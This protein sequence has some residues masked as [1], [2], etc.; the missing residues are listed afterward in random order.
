MSLEKERRRYL[1]VNPSMSNPI[2]STIHWNG[3]ELNDIPV[4]DISLGGVALNLSTDNAEPSVGSHFSD[5]NFFLPNHG[6]II[7]S[8][9]VRRVETDTSSNEVC[10]ALEFTRVPTSSDRLL[11]QYINARQRELSWFET[12]H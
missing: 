4:R 11:Y 1:R 10:C 8:G 2:M 9:I 6:V 12:G 5:M 7:A 3:Q